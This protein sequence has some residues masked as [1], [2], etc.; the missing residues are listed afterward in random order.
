MYGWRQLVLVGLALLFLGQACTSE[1][2]QEKAAR[3]LER[4]RQAWLAG[5]YAQA[6]TDYQ[7]YL[8]TFAQGAGR[9]E[10]WRRLIDI[11]LIVWGN[12]AAAVPLLD[13]ARL[14]VGPDDPALVDL[15]V[16][17]VDVALQMENTA[18]ALDVLQELGARKNLSP[19][20]RIWVALH[21]EQAY[22]KRLDLPAARQSLEACREMDLPATATAPCSLRLASLL[23]TSGRQDQASVIWQSVLQDG[24]VAPKWRAQAGFALAEAAEAR[25]DKDTARRLYKTIKD[26]YPNPM[27][28]QR[29]LDFLAK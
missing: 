18:K 28:I 7:H 23:A 11:A 2:P 17:T 21:R 10:A 12:P 15:L 29:K 8:Q 9:V 13:A 20:Q 26:W 1:P 14:E 5:N 24:T 3:Q 19:D 16:M 27:V 4:A 25:R 6:E 22:A